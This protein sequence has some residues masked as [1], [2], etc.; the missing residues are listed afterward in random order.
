MAYVFGC[1]LFAG[2]LCTLYEMYGGR[3]APVSLDHESMAVSLSLAR[4]I[5]LRS[6]ANSDIV[7]VHRPTSS[8]FTPTHLAHQRVCTCF[9]SCTHYLQPL[10]GDTPWTV[11]GAGYKYSYDFSYRKDDLLPASTR[12]AEG[13]VGS[14]AAADPFH[15]R[16]SVP[17]HGVITS[18]RPA[19]NWSLFFATCVCTHTCGKEEIVAASVTARDVDYMLRKYTRV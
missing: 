9:F 5:T 2:T 7:F 14:G 10:M 11:Y 1:I 6:T 17:T 4:G 8:F 18:S 15:I 13:V 3:H 16:L 12:W 19:G